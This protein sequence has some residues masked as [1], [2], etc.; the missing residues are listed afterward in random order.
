MHLMSR[1]GI[2]ALISLVVSSLIA[3]AGYSLGVW[4]GF[5][6]MVYLSVPFAIILG[7]SAVI[8]P[9]RKFDQKGRLALAVLVGTA[10]GILYAYFIIIRFIRDWP[11]FTV[12]GFLCWIPG[13]ISAMAAANSRKHVL[14]AIGIVVLC[15]STVVLMEPIFNAAAHNEQLTVALIT[16]SEIS[17]DQMEAQPGTLGFKSDEEIQ[18]AK[19]EVLEF[20]RTQGYRESFRVMSITRRGKGRKSLAILVVRTPI[21]KQV[22]LPVPDSAKL[23]YV[24]EPQNWA[25][26]PAQIPV[27]HRGITM[28][29]TDHM[30]GSLGLFEI[31]DARGI[32]LMGRISERTSTESR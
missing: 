19:D 13:G 5:P 29:P 25:K 21:T 26:I 31:P 3:L 17:A 12:L 1:F 22:V 23:V 8:V 16:P 18:N 2:A 15:L 4:M 32:S 20:M 27:L 7:V 24:Q 28:I 14:T 11:A 10:F 9:L 6:L 30:D